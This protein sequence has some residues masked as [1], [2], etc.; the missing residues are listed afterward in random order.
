MEPGTRGTKGEI[1]KSKRKKD[2]EILGNNDRKEY[3]ILDVI[4]N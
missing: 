4:N 3:C 1:I 2:F